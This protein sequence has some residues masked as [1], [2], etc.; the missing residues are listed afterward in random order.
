MTSGAATGR[1]RAGTAIPL[2]AASFATNLENLKSAQK[3][4]NG[5]PAYT[6]WI[7]RGLARRV[8]ALC[9]S[10]G[11]SANTVSAVSAAFSLTGLILLVAMPVSP[12]TGVLVAIF[13]ATGYLLDSADGQ[14]ARLTET[15]SPA[16]EWL[17]HVIDAV[18]TPAIHLS[19]AIGFI[20]LYGASAWQWWLPLAYC[21]VAASHFM[22]QILAEQLLRPLRSA[23]VTDTHQALT[24]HS[25]QQQRQRRQALISSKGRSFFMLHTDSGTLCWIFLVWGFA[26]IFLTLY[27]LLLVAN[28]LTAAVSMHRKYI[29]L[30]TAG[31][32]HSDRL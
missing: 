3:P 8:A 26:P 1:R 30:M 23:N 19:V 11:W 29:S 28:T 10:W 12:L 13:F 2:P 31:R 24:Q 5:V 25:D 9:A 6:R 18:R 14:V 20:H 16:G 27:G 7:N 15:G 32:A 4:G 17:D 21:I 22:S